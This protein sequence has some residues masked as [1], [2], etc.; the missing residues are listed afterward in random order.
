MQSKAIFIEA[1]LAK[2]G[3]FYRQEIERIRYY[4]A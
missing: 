2:A 1:A 4:R 3:R